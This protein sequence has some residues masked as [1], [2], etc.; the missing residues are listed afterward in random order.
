MSPSGI[1]TAP[2]GQQ[3]VASSHSC[4]RCLAFDTAAFVSYCFQKAIKIPARLQDRPLKAFSVSLR[5]SARPAHV[6]QRFGVRVLGD[7]HGRC[8]GDFAYQ[9][10]CGI[11]TLQELDSLASALASRS[12]SRRGAPQN[13]GHKM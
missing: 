11:K 7:L 8:V 13:R 1:R 3:S 2:S 12:P 6:L 4:T 10:D 5:I 9:K